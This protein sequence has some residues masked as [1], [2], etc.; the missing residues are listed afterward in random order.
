[1]YVCMQD[2]MADVSECVMNVCMQD[3]MARRHC[4]VSGSAWTPSVS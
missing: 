3:H 1:V 2:H 4:A